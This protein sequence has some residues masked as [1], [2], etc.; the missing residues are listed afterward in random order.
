MATTA[1]GTN[2]PLA[3]KLWSTKLFHE[4]LKETSIHKFTGTGSDSLIQVVR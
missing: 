1:F 4:A 2:H 3:V